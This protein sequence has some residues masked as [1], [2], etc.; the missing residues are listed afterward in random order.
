MKKLFLI[1]GLLTVLSLYDSA[2]QK[3]AVKTNLL[4]DATASLNLGV[5]TA[6]TQKW[7]LDVS[8]NWNPFQISE[9]RKW[10][11]WMVQPEARYWFCDSFQGHFLGVHALVGAYNITN[12]NIFKSELSDNRYQGYAAGAGVA[13]GYAFALSH[14]FNL[15]FEVGAGYVY[16]QYDRFEC[17]GCGKMLESKVPKHYVGPTKA[18]I[19]IVYIF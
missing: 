1:L 5:E 6:L 18:A 11:H 10:K 7:T 8:G 9:N 2:A 16:T 19:G 14:H 15:E 12:A 3:W 4:Y 13:Y 17:D